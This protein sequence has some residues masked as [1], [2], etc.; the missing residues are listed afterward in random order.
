M[1][2]TAIDFETANPQRS[3]ACAV[4]LVVVKNTQIVDSFYSLIRPPT[5]EFSERHIAIHQITPKHVEHKAPFCDVWP[6]LESRINGNIL[7]AHNAPFDMS[8]L[9]NCLAAYA[10]PSRPLRYACTLSMA[11]KLL[12]G[13]PNH[14]LTTLT[15]LFGIDLG[16][17][18]H[19]PLSDATACAYLAV[20]LARIADDGLQA[21][22]CD[23]LAGAETCEENNISDYDYRYREVGTDAFVP[24]C[25]LPGPADARFEG[26]RFTF[27]GRLLYLSRDDAENCVRR[28]GGVVSNSVSRKT[29]YVVVGDDVLNRFEKSGDTTGKLRKAI[30]L[31]QAGSGIEI[32][33]ECEFFDLFQDQPPT[34]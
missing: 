4:G 3:S 33:S 30:E 10:I 12:P 16:A 27:T 26:L 21:F 18:H 1:D 25:A 28:F 24:P 34:P 2:F 11:R 13:L 8:V 14:R 22:V 6:E 23:G 19:N 31:R 17:D 32:L 20:T 9:S 29:S 7:I 15:H 5:L